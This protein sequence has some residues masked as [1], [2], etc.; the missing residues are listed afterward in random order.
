MA[1]N[2]VFKADDV[3]FEDV[4]WGRTKSL[5]APLPSAGGATSEQVQFKVTEYAPGYSHVG[6]HHPGQLEVI[7]ILSGHGE[8]ERDDR[9]RVPIGPGDVIYVP[10]GSYHGNHNPNAEPLRAIIVKV[11]PTE[12]DRAGLSTDTGLSETVPNS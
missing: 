11:P 12:A 8:H 5:V 3:P 9:T 6:H 10:P 2:S 1:N 7:Y 4:S